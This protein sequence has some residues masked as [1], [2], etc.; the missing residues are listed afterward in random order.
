M[1]K[2]RV[3]GALDVSVAIQAMLVTYGNDV[4]EVID[5]AML[6]V[7]REAEDELKNVKRFSPNGDPSGE[8][9]KDWNLLVEPVKRYSR[10]FVVH[11]AEH[12]QLTH[13]LESGH[14]KFLWGRETGNRVPG[15]EH[16]RPINDRAQDRVIEEVIERITDLNTL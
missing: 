5:D 7:A 4:N 6:T 10:R 16:I 12:Y 2:K 3:V 8:Y 11:N 9:S 15:Y 13:L 1:A 14:A